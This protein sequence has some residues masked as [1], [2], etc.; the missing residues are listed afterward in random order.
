M[1]EDRRQARLAAS[2]AMLPLILLNMDRMGVQI[3]GRISF[4]HK[5]TV[6]HAPENISQ[7]DMNVL[8]DVIQHSY[9]NA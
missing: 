9:G 1:E 7:E 2:L 6:T 5:F 8:K 4:G 3:I